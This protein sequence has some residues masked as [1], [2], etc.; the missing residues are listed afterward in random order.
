[1]PATSPPWPPSGCGS[2]LD[3]LVVEL[4]SN[5]GYLLQHFVARGMPVLGV[6]P[7]RNVAAAAEQH[8]IPTLTKFFGEQLASELVA[9]GRGADLIVANNVL[10]QVPDLNDFVAGI[11]LLLKSSGTVTSSSPTWSA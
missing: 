5:D 4:A 7:A 1:M 9:Q 8:G 3:S 2:A 6:D 11:R 10:A